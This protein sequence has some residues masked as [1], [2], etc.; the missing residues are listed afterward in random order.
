MKG[1]TAEF[2][3][4]DR[5]REGKSAL[6]HPLPTQP[7]HLGSHS[8]VIHLLIYIPHLLVSLISFR[9]IL[10][11]AITAH[12]SSHVLWKLPPDHFFPTCFSWPLIS[13]FYYF[14]LAFWAHLFIQGVQSLYSW[15]S[16]GCDL[17]SPP[18]LLSL[19][20]KCSNALVLVLQYCLLISAFYLF[21]FFNNFFS[22][23]AQKEHS[24]FRSFCL[25]AL[26]QGFAAV[27]YSFL[28]VIQC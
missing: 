8:P 17:Y 5:E 3:G 19:G 18:L 9:W 26:F 16:T 24:C 1:T 2:N 22:F 25:C 4:N 23:S 7:P 12:H 6:K 28:S 15:C 20:G 13:P 11:T 27:I 14:Q 21:M 10:I